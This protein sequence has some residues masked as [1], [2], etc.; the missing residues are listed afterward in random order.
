M[1][2]KQEFLDIFRGNI[3]REGGDALL[4]YLDKLNA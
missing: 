3:H 2:D 1:D 4:D